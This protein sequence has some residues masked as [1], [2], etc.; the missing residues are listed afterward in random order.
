MLGIFA[1]QDLLYFFP[2]SYKYR[3]AVKSISDLQIEEMASVIATPIS[4]ETVFRGKISITKVRVRDETGDIDCIFHNQPYVKNNLPVGVPFI[5][6]GKV[7]KQGISNPEYDKEN[8]GQDS[9]VPLY[10]FSGQKII[11]KIMKDLLKNAT[12]VENLPL[13][14]REQLKL[15]TAE[16]SFRNIHFPENEAML[17]LA[18]RYFAT[19]EL[20]VLQLALY[21]LRGNIKKSSTVNI[22]DTDISPIIDNI[23]F[24]LTCSQKKVLDEIV[25]DMRSGQVMY[26]LLQGDVGSGKTVIAII[27][28]YISAKNGYQTAIMVPTGILA[29][30]HYESFSQILEPLG[31][32]VQLLTGSVKG[33]KIVHEDI[34]NGT[35]QVV[36]ATH[37]A[38][39]DNVVFCNL[40]LVI[41]DEQHRFGVRQRE[42]LA[43]KGRNPHVI[44][45]SA[46]PIPR[47]L[48]LILYGD[49]DI[50][51]IDQ[52]PAGRTAI[53]TY[54]VNTSYRER[55]WSFLEKEAMAGQ[56]SYIVCPAIE[57]DE[58]TSVTEYM[59]RLTQYYSKKNSSVKVAFLHGK[60]KENE[61][62]EIMQSFKNGSFA[63]LVATTV[64]E[65]G[66]NL[67]NA[68]VMVIEDA[69]RFGLS[70]L[71]QLRGRV[72]RG[73]AKS[74]CILI[75]D[76]TG[77]EALSRIRAMIDH[78]DG[79]H[80]SQMDLQLRGPGEFFG[81]AQHGI[82]NFK[83]ASLQRDMDIVKAIQGC[84]A[85][86]YR[87]IESYPNLKSMVD[88]VI[89]KES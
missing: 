41:T 54:H 39:S 59:D 42:A 66:V 71:H 67:Q 14:L 10:K 51:T 11:R 48:A 58:L 28:A 12:P 89:V 64:V 43:G 81:M 62:E 2:K 80:L 85:D 45:M 26:R 78:S 47:T 50:S 46:T 38:I 21:A 72:G 7:I 68:T 44:V 35:T 84:V 33:Q 63:V 60:M 17:S 79:F 82:L 18:Q 23:R 53:S 76:T 24:T 70:Q 1:V 75:S 34:K 27:A 36:V 4:A 3:G 69:H 65:V 20:I 15:P 52:L 74:Y 61:K 5:F 40:G 49:L 13:F 30:Q 25:E 37:A 19:E 57:S 29:A 86:I 88:K 87:D 9:I 55:I 56:Q 32:S 22:I 8:Q 16:E 6:S 83:M 31:I 73:S 77:E